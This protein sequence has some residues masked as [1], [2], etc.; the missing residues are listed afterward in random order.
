MRFTAIMVVVAGLYVT[1]AT[2]QTI[3]GIA[4]TRGDWNVHVTRNV[5]NDERSVEARSSSI[6]SAGIQEIPV[7]AIDCH[8]TAPRLIIRWPSKIYGSSNG[9]TMM[10]RVDSRAPIQTE[11]LPT[12]PMTSPSIVLSSDSITPKN[13]AQMAM[14]FRGA[15]RLVIGAGDQPG[16]AVI[17]SLDGFDR[18][19][20]EMNTIC[21]GGWPGQ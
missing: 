18:I 13:S 7:V 3:H 16:P 1:T 10:I 6:M 9:I 17:V 20:A 5:W 21:L 11:W 14:S 2:S 15:R 12:R 8:D 19:W 4:L